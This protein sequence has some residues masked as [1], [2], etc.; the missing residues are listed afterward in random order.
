MAKHSLSTWLD[1]YHDPTFRTASLILGDPD[2]ASEVV[3]EAFLRTWRFRESFGPEAS[4]RPWL[5]R[6]VVHC[7][8]SRVEQRDPGQ[9]DGVPVANMNDWSED[10]R[11]L[12]TMAGLPFHL[13]VPLVLRHFSELS[14]REIGLAIGRRSA[15]VRSRLGE[16][17]R[18]LADA[19]EA[20]TVD[21]RQEVGR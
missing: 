9:H 12:T 15:T 6:A 21:A 7:C 20:H 13:K 14:E 19:L 11:L 16:A 17:S 2:V 18:R 4:I 5:Y 10:A 1:E 8:Q 3:Q